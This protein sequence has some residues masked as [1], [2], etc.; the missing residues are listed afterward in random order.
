MKTIAKPYQSTI[1]IKKSKF[2][3]RL[4]P[5]QNEM[6]AKEII[7][8]ISEEFKDITAPH[9]WLAMEMAMMMMESLEEQ[10][11]GRCSMF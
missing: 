1:D 11:E 10:Q 4:Y 7:S 6:E 9:I 8:K 2:I 3:C 5:A